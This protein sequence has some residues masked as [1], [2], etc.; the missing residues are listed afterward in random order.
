[1]KVNISDVED[2]R[3]VGG[4]T[5]GFD[6]VAL[7]CF[8]GEGGRTGRCA[9]TGLARLVAGLFDTHALTIRLLTGRL[10]AAGLVS[11]LGALTTRLRFSLT[12]DLIRVRFGPLA[13]G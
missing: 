5:V 8:G 7:T 2:R 12:I 3:R 9:T 6:F 11:T 13:T 1:M 4:A 10:V